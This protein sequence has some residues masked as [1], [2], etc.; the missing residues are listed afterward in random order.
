M[1]GAECC[2]SAS[3][4]SLKVIQSHLGNTAIPQDFCLMDPSDIA[5]RSF[6]ARGSVSTHLRLLAS[7]CSK[8]LLGLTSQQKASI[9]AYLDSELLLWSGEIRAGLKGPPAGCRWWLSPSLTD[10]QVK[11]G[12]HAPMWTYAIHYVCCFGALDVVAVA[13][14]KISMAHAWR[15]QTVLEY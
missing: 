15:S 5:E 13:L 4:A 11:A 12:L 1:L 14:T 10:S 9:L 6:A 8:S 7:P 3:C 2:L